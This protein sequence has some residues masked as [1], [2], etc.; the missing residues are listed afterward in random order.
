MRNSLLISCLLVGVSVGASAAASRPNVLFVLIDDM[1]YGDLTCYG[2]TR[3]HTDNVDRLARE[4][5]RFTQ[6]YVNCPICSPSRTALLT[7]QYGARWKITSYLASRAEN[8]DRGMAQWLD[9]AAPTVARQLKAAGYATGHFGKWHMGGQR[10]VGDAPLITEYGFDK[11]LTTF[12]GLGDRVLPLLD[13]YD[14]QP[15]EK[16]SLGS[17]KLGRGQITWV[18]RSKVTSS[19]VDAAMDFIRQAEKDGRPFYVDI[20]PDDVHSPFFPPKAL[21]GDGSKKELYLGVVQATD[22]QLGPL[23]DYVRN[24]PK[25]R[26]NTLIVVASDNGP[27]PGAGSAGPFRGHKG[28]LYEGGVRE[29]LIVWGPGLVATSAVGTTNSRTVVAGVDF[30]PSVLAIAGQRPAADELLDGQDMSPSL[31]G[32]EQ[33]RRTKPL[34]WLR[35]PDRP[36]PE[37][38][39]FPDLSVRDGDWKLLINEDGSRPQLY[40][41]SSDIGEKHNRAADHPDIVERLKKMV[42]QWRQTLPVAPVPPKAQG[43]RVD[44]RDDQG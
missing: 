44:V 17:D 18:D 8:R 43:P 10:D 33:A 3:V 40:D 26:D 22:D 24:S 38:D 9:P 30:L 39:P 23:L 35:P 12:E 5:I 36:G 14:G 15:A 21:R 42:L 25:L 32:R 31:L 6:F 1:G 19:F 4:G 28:N 27:E 16:Y 2:N 37:A 11:T 41:L 34:F 7:G 13:A 29:P 20:W